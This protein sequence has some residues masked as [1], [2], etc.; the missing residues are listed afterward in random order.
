[1][2]TARHMDP[3]VVFLTDNEVDEFLV[4]LEK[5]T[6]LRLSPGDARA[7][8]AQLLRVLALIRDVAASAADSE[9]EAV[10][11]HPCQ[12]PSFD[13]SIEVSAS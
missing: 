3:P 11:R 7:L 12:N 1:M 5:H 9:K 6:T 4:L 10:D 2:K 8:S 13:Q